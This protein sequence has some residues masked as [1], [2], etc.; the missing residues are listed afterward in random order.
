MRLVTWRL[1]V[2]TVK[3]FVPPEGELL[4]AIEEE[5]GSLDGFIGKFNTAAAGVQ[6]RPSL[7]TLR[8]YLLSFLYFI[9]TVHFAAFP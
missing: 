1:L 4:K 2:V 5:F 8:F 3:E 9:C 6:V 7:A